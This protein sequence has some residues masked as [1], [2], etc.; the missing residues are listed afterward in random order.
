M[1]HVHACARYFANGK[2][3][4]IKRWKKW[5]TFHQISQQVS[6]PAS[7]STH[8]QAETEKSASAKAAVVPPSGRQV[9]PPLLGEEAVVTAG[10]Q[11]LILDSTGL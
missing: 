11:N 6:S 9:E 7:V 3:I 5:L 1:L 8:Q 10:K 4:F 2:S